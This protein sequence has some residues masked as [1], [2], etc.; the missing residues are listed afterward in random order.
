MLIGRC[1]VV[2]ILG[3]CAF[4]WIS[5]HSRRSGSVLDLT[6]SWVFFRLK[7]KKRWRESRLRREFRGSSS[8]TQKV[9][10]PF[11]IG[12]GKD[13]LGTSL[14]SVLFWCFS[15]I[16]SHAQLWTRDHHNSWHFGIRMIIA[17]NYDHDSLFF[18]E[19]VETRETKLLTFHVNVLSTSLREPPD[20]PPL[21]PPKASCENNL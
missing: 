21:L 9:R 5:G 20:A 15:H 11:F 2:C 12:W 14:V 13:R 4:V 8:W 1:H 7:W 18:F 19:M 16:S 3:F 6:I 10:A 17:L